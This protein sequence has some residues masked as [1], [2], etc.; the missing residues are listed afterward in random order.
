MEFKM[1]K[2]NLTLYLMF[3]TMLSPAIIA[4]EPV[5][6]NETD[7]MQIEETCTVCLDEGSSTNFRQLGLIK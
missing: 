5:E 3:V 1:K 7:A 2:R 6:N 4:M